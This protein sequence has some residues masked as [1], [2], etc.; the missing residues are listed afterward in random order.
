M[1]ENFSTMRNPADSKESADS[2]TE[3]QG[4]PSLR[5][6]NYNGKQD[7]TQRK[8]REK[9]ESQEHQKADSEL[10]SSLSSLGI[11]AN[12]K[13]LQK[14]K[15]RD[16]DVNDKLSTQQK[17]KNYTES[18]KDGK[19]SQE[20]LRLLIAKFENEKGVETL[21]GN[22]KNYL[23]LYQFAESKLPAERKAIQKII[24]KADFTSKSAFS[25]SLAEI[26]QS[27]K[28]SNE[29]KLEI[30][31]NFSGAD[32]FSVDDLDYGLK[33]QKS[34]KNEIENAITKQNNKQD[35]LDSEIESLQD[36]LDSLPRNDPKRQELEDK[37][38]QKKEVL[39][40]TETEIERL[41]KGK[42]KNI[43][44]TLRKGFSAKLNPDGSR[45]I[46]IDNEGFSIKLPSNKWL[47][48]DKKNMRA[49][50]LSF[51]YLAL[52]NQN[53]ADTL[54][55]S[56][57]ENNAVP[58]KSQRDMGHLILES[59]GFDDAKILSKENIN[60]LNKDLSLLT[61]VRNGKS[62]KEKL[63][64]LGVFDITS[65]SLDKIKFRGILKTICENRGLKNELVFK[66]LSKKS[67][68]K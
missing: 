9:T 16:L 7:E 62:A 58:S 35:F 30:S 44:F 41:E 43:S 28:I 15:N 47:F 55:T 25:T 68:T 59:L 1:P 42:P 4:L 60:Q 40:K 46:R 33:L 45:S 5:Q 23:K 64:D 32:V 6:H 38:E 3:N 17:I 61:S 36:E 48:S 56:S 24:A 67:P 27:A 21:V 2:L 52:K 26:S 10:E 54:F 63:I 37:I 18:I 34:R 50:N 49:I 13:E 53:I 57:I 19:S 31:R 11:F 20:I 66:K 51:P 14:T 65:Q 39:E 29:T 12:K 8:S 22:F